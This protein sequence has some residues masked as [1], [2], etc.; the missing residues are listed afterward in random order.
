MQGI[1][2]PFQSIQRDVRNAP[3]Q[4]RYVG[5]VEIR[6]LGHDFLAQAAVFA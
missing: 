6:Q 4:L 1:R 3:L 5:P 2:Q